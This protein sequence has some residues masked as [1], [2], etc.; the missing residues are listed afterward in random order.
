MKKFSKIVAESLLLCILGGILNLG[1]FGSKVEAANDPFSADENLIENILKSRVDLFGTVLKD[2]EKYEIQILYTQIN[3]DKNNIPSFKS[4]KYRVDSNNYFYPA[5][6]V[7]LSA[8]VLALEKLNHLNI[9]KNTPI[10]IEKGRASQKAAI[11]DYST[12]DK[13]PTVANYIKKVLIASDNDGFDR[14]YEFLG[15]EYYNETLWA[16]GYKNIKI[17][18]R[19]D[20]NMNNEENKYTNPFR[21][22][23]E[24]KLV[25]EQPMVYNNKNY[26]NNINGMSKGKGYVRGRT[27]IPSP[28]DFSKSNYFS[29]E[30]LQ[31]ILKSIMFPEQV[32]YEQRFNLKQDDYE[33]LRKYMSMLPRECDNPKYSFKDSNFKYFIFG[34][35]N[36]PIPSNIKVYNKIGCAYGYLI[37]NAYITDLEKGIE[38][39]LTSVIYTNE[40]EIFNDGKY[41]YYK[42]GMP[43]LANLGRVIYN[44]EINRR[45]I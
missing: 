32:P 39:M 23:N 17:L 2:P 36:E 31:G 16:K 1:T 30:C 8:C 4:F 13:K 19:L 35:T 15:Q 28:K 26:S 22:Y 14:L 3:R 29:V 43:F 37:D 44:Y 34:D 25:Y 38:F 5:S 9:D 45:K 7:K 18:H 41:E 42:V 33:F 12:K 11:Y 24:E 10:R 20:N 40:N 6:S 21:F 27:F